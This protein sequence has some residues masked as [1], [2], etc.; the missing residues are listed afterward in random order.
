MFLPR[1]AANARLARLRDRCTGHGPRTWSPR[2]WL[3]AKPTRSSTSASCSRARASR[4]SSPGMLRLLAEQ[5]RGTRRRPPCVARPEAFLVEGLPLAQHVVHRP[6]QPR[7]QDRH[8]LAAATLRRLP[9][10]PFLGPL[11]ALQE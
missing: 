10:L 8:G 2:R 11:A 4:K 7:R 3:G 6:P 9:L 5:R 1:W